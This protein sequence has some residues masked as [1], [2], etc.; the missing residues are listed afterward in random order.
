[1]KPKTLI[2]N[3]IKAGF[4]QRGSDMK[5]RQTLFQLRNLANQA[6]LAYC[7]TPNKKN[8][9]SLHDADDMLRERYRANY[10][11]NR[12]KVIGK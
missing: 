7:D 9:K 2:N 11:K 10:R 8:E 3:L 4:S 5:S 6:Y 1:M 12:N